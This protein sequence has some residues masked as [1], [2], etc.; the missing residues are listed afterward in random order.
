MDGRWLYPVG[1][2]VVHP[3]HGAGTVI[4]IQAKSIGEMCHRY[5]I[6]DTHAMR[7]M[8]PVKGADSIG[9][10]RVGRLPRLRA[11][12]AS[13]CQPPQEAEIS[14]DHR[15]RKAELDKELK[16]GSF[17]KA[18]HAARLLYFLNARRSLGIV[19]RRLYDR[20]MNMLASE[21]ALASD[22]PV[23]EAEEEI[24]RYLERMLADETLVDA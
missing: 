24:E 4:G 6:I 7:L 12:L 16:S 17:E 9:L 19:D 15:A 18:V 21:L 22:Q 3:N 13:C 5:Y 11:A 10:R 23:Q 14:Q 1:S 8:V 2:K 20:A